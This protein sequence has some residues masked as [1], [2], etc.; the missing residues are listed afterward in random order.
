VSVDKMG[1]EVNRV[2]IITRDGVDSWDR[3]GK[4]AV[5]TRLAERIA[6]ALAN[7]NAT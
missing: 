2:H 6:D 4:D 3:M 5:A 1:G 7:G